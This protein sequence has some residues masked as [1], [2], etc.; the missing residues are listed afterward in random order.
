MNTTTTANV[1]VNT[2]ANANVNINHK[3]KPMVSKP[4]LYSH[5]SAS[6][7]NNNMSNN[8]NRR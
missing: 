1:N 5:L 7:T 3:S 4:P 8:G 6:L 2:S